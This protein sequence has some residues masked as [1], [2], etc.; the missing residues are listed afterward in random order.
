M[1]DSGD[2]V[3]EA[4]RARIL[5]EERYRAQVRAQ[6]EAGDRPPM[7]AHVQ[8]LPSSQAPPRPPGNSGVGAVL[9]LLLGGGIFGWQMGWF[10]SAATPGYPGIGDGTHLV[11]QQMPPGRYRTRT[12]SPG[13]Y[14]ARLAGTTGDPSQIHANENTDGP[15]IV[16]ISEGDGA[17]T[18]RGCAPWTRDTSTIRPDPS[19]P[20]QEGTFLVGTEITPGT[21]RAN[22]PG[23]CYWARLRDFGG[24]VHSILANANGEGVVTIL[25]DDVGF[26][27]TR[28]GTW[29]RVQ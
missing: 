6:L 25:P 23:D 28:C 20:F 26:R 16:D 7:D 19:T 2:G 27:S 5:A 3:D 14:W 15:A 21:W 4:T 17:F 18:S 12:S 24:G 22:N 11:G 8:V 1:T 13:C 9:G 10:S 29:T